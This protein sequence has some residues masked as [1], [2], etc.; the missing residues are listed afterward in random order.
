M[1]PPS[2]RARYDD[3]VNQAPAM[4]ADSQVLKSTTRWSRSIK[5]WRRSFPWLVDAKSEKDGVTYL[6]CEICARAQAGG[7]FGEFQVLPWRTQKSTLFNHAASKSHKCAV[8]GTIVG[9]PTSKQFRRA[10]HLARKGKLPEHLKGIGRRNKLRR[11]KWCLAEAVRL[12]KME[13]LKMCRAVALHA[14][15]RKG[16]LAVRWTGCD[17]EQL[18][19]KSGVL[20]TVSLVKDFA[21]DAIGISK[22][23]QKLS[24]MRAPLSQASHF[25]EF[26]RR[27]CT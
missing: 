17:Q 23:I 21:C 26:T 6:G 19:L 2:K 11:M 13:E 9:V 16:R 5:D 10:L 14:D 3:G 27:F 22:A 24:R 8:S 12:V 1:Q 4:Q 20:G 25:R 7:R 18:V 15:A